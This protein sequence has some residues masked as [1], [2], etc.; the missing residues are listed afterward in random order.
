ADLLDRCQRVASSW[1]QSSLGA[2]ADLYFRDFQKPTGYEI[3]NIEWGLLRGIPEGWAVRTPEE[4]S[5]R[6]EDGYSGLPLATINTLVSELAKRLEQLKDEVTTEFAY[7]QPTGVSSTE[8]ALGVEIEQLEIRASE[9]NFIGDLAICP[10]VSRDSRSIYQGKRVAPHIPYQAKIMALIETLKR[11]QFF[12]RS[13]WK[14]ISLL[15]RHVSSGGEPAISNSASNANG[16][17]A[18]GDIVQRQ[19]DIVVVCAL[20]EPELSK[21]K[22]LAD[23]WEELPHLANDPHRYLHSTLKISTGGTI[24]VVIAAPNQMGMTASAV[25]ATKMILKFKPKL[26][27]MVGIAAGL[28]EEQGFGDILAPT[29]TYDYASGKHAEQGKKILFKPDP[30]PFPLAT[31]VIQSLKHWKSERGDRLDDIKRKWQG[32]R[33]ASSLEM[34]LGPM[35]SGPSVV[36]SSSIAQDVI[37][38]WRTA[39]GL[40]MEAYAVHSAACEAVEPAPY[41]LCLKSV[42]DFASEKNDDW[43]EYAAYTA[44]RCFAKFIEDEWVSLFPQRGDS[45]FP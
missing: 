31:R 17:P 42:C 18:T 26:V 1:T 35:G 39:I 6:V 40:E 44:A 19:F 13:A 41:F 5:K 37:K 23:S 3:F 21:I 38:H 43:Q 36:N 25:L 2:H 7:A 45:N 32:K 4:T 15:E 27:A 20:H 16:T 9:A 14:L 24:S 28:R 34:H 22:E 30:R 29:Q 11:S 8:S 33:P 12:L 10:R